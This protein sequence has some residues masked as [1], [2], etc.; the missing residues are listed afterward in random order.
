MREESLLSLPEAVRRMTSLPADTLRLEG[1]GRLQVGA[2][3]DVV[4]FDSE[5][6][7]DRATLEDPRRKATGVDTVLAA[8]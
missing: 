5:E 7:S 1:R 2:H 8:R 6:I 4:L 3:A